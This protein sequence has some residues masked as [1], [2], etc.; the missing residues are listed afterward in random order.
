MEIKEGFRTRTRKI[1]AKTGKVYIYTDVVPI[2]QKRNAP[3]VT[4]KS[5]NK[6][7]NYYKKKGY[8]TN[9]NSWQSITKRM[10]C[11]ANGHCERCGGKF[12]KLHIH[13]KDGNGVISKK[14]NNSI[15]NLIVVCPSC[16]VILHGLKKLTQIE[17]IIHLRNEGKTLQKIG[18]AM[19]LSRQR[20]SRILKD[21]ADFPNG[22]RGY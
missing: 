9:P 5:G 13:H 20:V 3:L 8:P 22:Y 10:L 16:H 15:E 6:Y 17:T 11:R 4:S 18:G 1:M 7:Y 21:Y 14:P 12:P 2:K 19:N